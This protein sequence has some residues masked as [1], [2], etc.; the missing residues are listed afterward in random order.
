[1]AVAEKGVLKADAGV[2]E[3]GDNAGGVNA[4]KGD[5]GRAPASGPQM[6]C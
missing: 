1:M 2:F 4:D 6:S 5:D 3:A